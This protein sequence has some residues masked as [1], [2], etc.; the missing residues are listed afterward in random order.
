MH[1]A[2]HP[3][4]LPLGGYI[5][6]EA[7]GF[8]HSTIDAAEM[9]LSLNLEGI[10]GSFWRL[11]RNALRLL[12]SN[13]KVISFATIFCSIAQQR[14]YLIY[15][16]L[17]IHFI[18]LCLKIFYLI[19]LHTWKIKLI[20]VCKKMQNITKLVQYCCDR[21]AN[22]NNGPARDITIPE[23]KTPPSQFPMHRIE[24]H[25]QKIDMIRSPFN[26]TCLPLLFQCHFVFTDYIFTHLRLKYIQHIHSFSG[27]YPVQF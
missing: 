1:G 18:I 2:L 6:W 3:H 26:Q 7:I 27:L 9:R 8:S 22:N 13:T 20:S 15:F 19:V 21:E 4:P 25:V 5:I 12:S 16:L 10:Q 24:F 14:F 23:L 11:L 17:L